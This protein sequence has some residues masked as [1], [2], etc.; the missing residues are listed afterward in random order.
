MLKAVEGYAYGENMKTIH[1]FMARFISICRNTASPDVI[2]QERLFI[3]SAIGVANSDSWFMPMLTFRKR[4]NSS[5]SEDMAINGVTYPYYI[6][7]SASLMFG[8]YGEVVLYQKPIKG[9]KFTEKGN[10]EEDFE[11]LGE[12]TFHITVPIDV[13]KNAIALTKNSLQLI[14]NSI[15]SGDAES[16]EET[17]EQIK[18]DMN[19]IDDFMKTAET[20]KE[21]ILTKE[22]TGSVEEESS[23]TVTEEC[24]VSDDPVKTQKPKKKELDIDFDF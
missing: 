7:E 23:E 17:V 10:M 4:N 15:E 9:Y 3:G 8:R 2:G 24:V 18:E 1:I 20:L 19:A 5:M 16:S 13:L 14:L 6:E 11:N 22:E 21:P 12:G